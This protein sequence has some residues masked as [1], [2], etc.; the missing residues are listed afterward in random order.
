[1]ARVSVSPGMIRWARERAALDLEYLLHKFSKLSEWET[2]ELQP[3]L[4]QLEKFAKAVYV[5]FGFLFLKKPPIEELPIPDFRTFDSQEIK[6]LSP[7]LLDM[8]YACQ[9]RQSW[10]KDYVQINQL[11]PCE[12][13]GSSSL[14]DKPEDVAARISAAIGFDIASRNKCRNYEETLRLLIQKADDVGIL[15]MVSGVVFSNNNRKLDP[16]EFRG[17]AISDPLA[18]LVF[19]NGSDSKAG[20]IF[21]LAHELAH[22]WLDSTALSNASAAPAN[23]FRKEEVWCNAV[24]AELLVPTLILRSNLQNR[25]HETINQATAR[26]SKYFKVSNLVI[27]R[28]LLDAGWL[29]KTEFNNEWDSEK[30]RLKEIFDQSAGGGNFYHTTLSRVSRRFSRALVCSTLEGHTLYRDAFRMLG[31]SKTETF[32]NLGREVG[33]ML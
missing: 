10:Y 13:I 1:M 8:I 32:N 6:R 5:P 9:E 20:Q 27:L 15:V 29:S 21:T 4:K 19:V 18:P 33:V 28:R 11:A 12:M 22:L 7:N 2:G 24:A 30:E 16:K 3:T 17:F 14:K 31:I 26:L 25:S 23:G